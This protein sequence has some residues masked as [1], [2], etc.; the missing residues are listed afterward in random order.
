MLGDQ[1][2]AE[3]RTTIQPFQLLLEILLAKEAFIVAPFF[4]RI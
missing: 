1:S 2:L 4:G 3:N